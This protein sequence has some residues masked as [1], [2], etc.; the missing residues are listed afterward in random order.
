VD[1]LPASLISNRRTFA[2][3]ATLSSSNKLPPLVQ[4]LTLGTF[5]MSTTE[6]MIAGLLPEMAAQVRPRPRKP[7]VCSW[8]VPDSPLSSVS[9][10]VRWPDKSS[11][12]EA[13]SGTWQFS[14]LY[15]PAWFPGSFPR[16]TARR[17]PASAPKSRRC[18]TAGS[19]PRH[20]TGTP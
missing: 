10:S 16:T 13:R 5:L 20:Q 11:G 9:R 7:W 4:L 19:G 14:R 2:V 1:R 8:A 15:R 17:L 3:S 12:G 6:F 18:A